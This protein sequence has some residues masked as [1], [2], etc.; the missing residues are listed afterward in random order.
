M[1][2]RILSEEKRPFIDSIFITVSLLFILFLA[3]MISVVV[4]IASQVTFFVGFLFLSLILILFISKN[5]KWN[6]YGFSFSKKN[7]IKRYYIYTPLFLLAFMPIFAGISADLTIRKIIYLIS[8]MALVAFVE[9]TIFRGIILKMMLKK[10]LIIAIFWSSIL[11]SLSHLLNSLGTSNTISI[12]TQ[13][14]YAFVIGIILSVIVIKTNNIFITILFHYLNN[15]MTSLNPEV[16]NLLSTSISTIMF[17]MAVI[18][19]I[20]L[21]SVYFSK[22]LST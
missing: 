16:E 22:K 10:G 13:T 3:G 6:Y 9:E 19:L 4:N 8:Y 1:I 5:K 20:Y 21:Y 18:Y 12:I 17:A 2:R 11:F 15:I 14:S 7:E